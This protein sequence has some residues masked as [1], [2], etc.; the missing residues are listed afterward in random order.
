MSVETVEIRVGCRIFDF[1]KRDST[2]GDTAWIWI[3]LK[4]GDQHEQVWDGP[5]GDYGSV[6][7]TTS[8]R[9]ILRRHCPELLAQSTDEFI[10]TLL[11][12]MERSSEMLGRLLAE[13]AELGGDSLRR[14]IANY[15]EQV[16]D[17]ISELNSL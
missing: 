8:V 6:D 16:D 13:N 3:I 5:E 12:S 10:K 15:D 1:V 7:P 14:S 4:N 17:L 2:T 9:D 11:L